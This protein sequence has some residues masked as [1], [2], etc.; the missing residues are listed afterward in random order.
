MASMSSTT[1]P[2]VQAWPTREQFDEARRSLTA[3]YN[4]LESLVV[5]FQALNGEY[6]PADI[7]LESVPVTSETIAATVEFLT[8][9]EIE[10]EEVA[11]L[12]KE[13]TEWPGRLANV[14]LDQRVAMGRGDA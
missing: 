8:E 14:R 13:I 2:G 4:A 6:G 5:E 12:H 7:A 1:I 11:R 9:T 3:A 10:L